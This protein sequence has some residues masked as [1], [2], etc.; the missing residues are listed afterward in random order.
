MR[1]ISKRIL[2]L[3]LSA[4]MVASLTACGGKDD[5]NNAANTQTPSTEVSTEQAPVA[6]EVKSIVGKTYGT[7]YTSLY[8]AV[9][10]NITIADVTEDP[11]TGFAY[12]TVDGVQ[13]EL[14]MDFLSMAMVYNCQVPEGG[15]WATADDVY[16]TWW[17][18]Y[19]QRWNY[20]LPEI[21]LYANEYYDL[22]N[23]AIGGVA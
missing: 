13:Y 9:G 22:Y 10:K 15:Q 20:L 11:E 16:A 12:I 21:P 4:A 5:S 7:D 18:L 19:I 2:A 3:M 23:T 6:A 17:K 1:K 8:D 14:G